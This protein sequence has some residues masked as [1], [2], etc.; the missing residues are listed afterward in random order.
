M[1]TFAGA[2][3]SGIWRVLARAGLRWKRGRD[4]G[5]SPDPDYHLTLAY[6]ELVRGLV[7]MA[8]SRRR[9]ALP[10]RGDLLSPAVA[11]RR[12][13]RGRRRR[14]TG[15]AVDPERY[16]HPGH[17]RP[18]CPHRPGHRRPAHPHRRPGP[19]PL[20]PDPGR[21]LSG[22]TDLPRPGQLADPLPSRL[23]WPP[24]NPRPPVAGSGLHPPGRPRPARGPSASTSRSSS[25]RSPP[26]PPGP[27]PSRRSGAGS[28]RT[29]C[30]STASPTT[31]PRSG[32]SSSTSSPASS[33]APPNSSAT[34]ASL[35]PR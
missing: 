24:S 16:H 32:P 1:P 14:A 34:S 3:L 12:L 22:P 31:S 20:L 11:R 28:S 4:H 6:L 7:A 23:S 25:S 33:T 15:R 9:A 29:C 26:T 35:Y 27:I 19:D 18:R 5:R 30:T 8:P 2:S 21:R 10:G 13:R 17:R